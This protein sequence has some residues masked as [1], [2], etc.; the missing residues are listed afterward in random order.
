MYVW[1]HERYNTP[2]CSSGVPAVS[3]RFQAAPKRDSQQYIFYTT[4]F[5]TMVPGNHTPQQHI[6]VPL[7][8]SLRSISRT[9][10]QSRTVSYNGGGNKQHKPWRIARNMPQNQD[11]YLYLANKL[12]DPWEAELLKYVNTYGRMQDF[13][14]GQFAQPRG[15]D[16]WRHMG[17]YEDLNPHHIGA[18]AT[19]SLF[20]QRN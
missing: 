6:A 14:G 20:D 3:L 2:S 12:L 11:F 8:Q 10:R 9:K 15:S 1:Q 18:R 17:Q 13:M 19:G 4:E 16:S 5:P 7:P